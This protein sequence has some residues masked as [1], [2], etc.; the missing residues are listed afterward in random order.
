MFDEKDDSS[1][2]GHD[3][4]YIDSVAE[5]PTPPKHRFHFEQSDLDCV[6]RRLKQRHVQMFVLFT[7]AFKV[8]YAYHLSLIPDLFLRIAVSASYPLRF[9]LCP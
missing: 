6:Q 7:Y 5:H 9:C 2:P 1:R 4:R 3:N 8:H